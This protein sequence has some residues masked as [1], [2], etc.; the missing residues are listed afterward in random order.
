[1]TAEREFTLHDGTRAVLRGLPDGSEATLYW[2]AS[3]SSVPNAIKAH[4][5]RARDLLAT[6]AQHAGGRLRVADVDPQP[7][8]DQ[9]AEALNQGLRRVPM[10][11]GDHFFLGVTIR[12]GDRVARIPYLD[13]RRERLMEYDLAVALQ[14]LSRAEQAKIGVLSP[15]LPP[16]IAERRPEGLSFMAE[17]KRAYD[18]AVIPPFSETLPEGL[19]A[20]LLIDA[21]VLRSEMLYAI[22]QFVM[23]GGSVVALL[24]PF[25]RFK[26]A[27]NAVNPAPSEEIN[28]LS[29]LLLRYGIRY[30]GEAVVGDRRLA[31]PVAD[32]QQARLSFPYWLRLGDEQLSEAHATTAD[33]NEVFL[34]EPGHLTLEQDTAAVALVATTEDSGTAPR[35]GYA[36]Q[37]PQD[38]ARS[39]ASDDRVRLLAAAVEGPFTS[40]YP[41]AP[42]GVQDWRGQSTG[43]PVVLAVADVDWVFD[44]F[45]L[46]TAV[47]GEETITRPLND[48]L[49]FLLNLVEFASGD[50]SL[51]AIRSRGQLQR[52][53]TRVARMFQEAETRYRDKE[54]AFAEQAAALEARIGEILEVSGAGSVDDLPEAAR[55]DLRAHYDDLVQVRRA[56]GGV[57][58]QIRSAVDRLGRRIVVANLLAGPL[59]VAALALVVMLRRD[60]RHRR[61][62]SA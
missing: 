4:A 13:P 19:D 37:V 24:D 10:T 28:D 29:D 39:F 46:Q 26:P 31:A 15:L 61:L 1:M 33:L 25:L 43:N 60:R 57:R 9:E 55:A 7:D 54:V 32:P 44:P 18:V 27:S 34:V 30:Q 52:P 36:E 14:G 3:E 17:L 2:S 41:E 22:D 8:S 11:S 62:P 50:A 16:S 58:H 45:S 49:A 48:N 38:L 12:S 53:F 6:L 20:L 5:R 35:D 42:D 59:L 23:R 40:A 56:I 47:L 51:I 21:T